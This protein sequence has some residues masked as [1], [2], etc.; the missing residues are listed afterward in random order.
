MLRPG[1]G[2]ILAVISLLLIGV[3]MVT[4]A[5]L[6]VGAESA[7]GITLRHLL[8]GRP[9]MF[10]ALAVGLMLV[11][12]RIPVRYLYTGRGLASPIWWIVFSCGTPLA[13]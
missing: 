2:L 1:H 12:W 11:A 10:A 4:S 5:G 8:L 3:V 13:S 6:A 9:A 7:E